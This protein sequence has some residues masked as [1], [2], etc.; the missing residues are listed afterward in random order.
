MLDNGEPFLTFE[1]SLTAGVPV[2]LELTSGSFDPYLVVLDPAGELV[3][4]VDDSPGM[5]LNVG[6]ASRP[7]PPAPSCS[8]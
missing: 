6:C 3:L 2:Y 5:D 1:R 8:R 7:P 4:E